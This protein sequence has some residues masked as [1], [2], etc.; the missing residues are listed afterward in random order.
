MEPYLSL[1]LGAGEASLL[2]V[3]AAYSVFPNQGV[4]M[5]P[6][7]VLQDRRPRQGNLLEENRPRLEGRHPGRHGVRDDEPAARRR[8]ARHGGGRGRAR[9]AARRQDRHDR[10]LHRRL[11]H[12]LR[13]EHHVGV[14][15]GYDDKKPLGPAETGAAAALPI[16]MDFMRA[17][18]EKRGDR[19]NPPA[20]E[21]PGQHRVRHRGPR[22]PASRCRPTR[23]GGITEAFIAGTQPGG[24]RQ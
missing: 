22:P 19:A 8:A 2:E 4:R 11:V 16:W 20:F 1:A 13:P 14:W 21:A 10:R 24:F 23:G 17:Y 12:R 7:Q 5:K 3:V 18:I 15:V 9:L 6:F